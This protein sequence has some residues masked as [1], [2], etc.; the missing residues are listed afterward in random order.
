M[1]KNN[2]PDWEDQNEKQGY[3]MSTENLV[4]KAKGGDREAFGVL[5]ERFERGV[6]AIAMVRM[7][8]FYEA[9]ELC[10][11]VF[12]Q[13]FLKIGQLHELQAFG[14]WLKS[15]THRMAINRIVR[16]DH[17][18]HAADG[19]IEVVLGFSGKV[20][21]ETPLSILLKRERGN[22][23]RAGVGGL[24][25]MD[26]ETL[27]AFYEQ[28]SSL[29]QMSEEFDAPLGTIKRRLHTARHR[30]KEDLEMHQVSD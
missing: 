19:D 12:L 7:R 1:S 5:Y 3:A 13:A 16:K 26:R 11:E 25:E 4:V 2:A 6:F 27:L 10:Q 17:L 28:N 22:M 23:V 18:Q 29:I 8:D 24:R 21:T 15:I 30:L 14:G 9:Q 20:E